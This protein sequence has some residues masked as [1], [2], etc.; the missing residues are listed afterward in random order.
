M[1]GGDRASGVVEPIEFFLIYLILPSPLGPGVYSVSNRNEYQKQ[2][3]K[4]SEE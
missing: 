2:K 4:V 1:G 3:K